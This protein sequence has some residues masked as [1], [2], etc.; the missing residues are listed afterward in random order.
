MSAAAIA[1]R[2]C[3]AGLDA[4]AIVAALEA[5]ESVEEER[6]SKTRERKRRQ[7]AKEA[8][9]ERDVTGQGVTE[10]DHPFSLE[11]S[12]HTPL[13]KPSILIPPSPPKGGSSPKDF[14]QFWEAY[15]AKIGKKAAQRAWAK[16]K[17]RPPLPDLLAALSRY[18]ATKPP[19]RDWCN[20]ATWINQG[21]WDDETEVV[22]KLGFN[23]FQI[24]PS[25][26]TPAAASPELYARHQALM[27]KD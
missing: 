2:L 12:P 27:G 5:F 24:A 26:P 8:V 16:A 1:R 13:P 23:G 21:R 9:T 22:A 14:D 6:R 19:D 7:R 3:D 4:N 11:V 15:P 10:R 17:D 25:R 18:R 20:P